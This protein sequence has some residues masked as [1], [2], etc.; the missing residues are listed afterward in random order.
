M[1]MKRFH[2]KAF[3][4]YNPVTEDV[5]VDSCL[6]GMIEDNRYLP[7]ESIT[8]FFPRLME[9]GTRTKISQKDLKV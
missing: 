6:H 3:C 2:E 9:A 5:L 4:C 1:L 8:F 7:K